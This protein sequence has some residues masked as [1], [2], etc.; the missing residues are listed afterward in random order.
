MSYP[1][2]AALVLSAAA[3]TA[4]AIL[5]APSASA[6]TPTSTAFA[7]SA[8]GLL[9]IARIP[10]VS[11][12]H[13]FSQESVVDFSTPNRAVRAKVLNAEAGSGHAKA[14]ITDLTVDLSPAKGLPLGALTL[15]ATAVE[16]QCDHATTRSS[17]ASARLG[18]QVLAVSAPA[19]TTIDVAGLVSV[20]L[21]K[22]TPHEDGSVTVTAISIT[23][24]G[25]QTLD[26]ASATCG[27]DDGGD[28]SQPPTSAPTTL[29]TTTSTPIDGGPADNT[30]HPGP[31]SPVP[32]QAPRP[33]PVA[34]HLDVTG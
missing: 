28:G 18:K 32:G 26:I 19:N 11:N 29:P 8:N 20:V 25:V 31:T 1:R 21:N 7:L 14:S 10:N 16:S 33:T 30:P 9:T 5:G 3:L 2:A 34:G 12:A 27:A 6:D 17:L 23:V 22:K 4:G 24:T 15:T 13:G